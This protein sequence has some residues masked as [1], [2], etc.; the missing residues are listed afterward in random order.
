[1][2]KGLGDIDLVA[3]VGGT[4]VPIE[5]KSFRIWSQFLFFNGKREA[6]TIAQAGR[7]KSRLKADIAFVWL[8][9]GRPTMLQR[10]FGAGGSRDIKVIFGSEKVLADALAR[11]A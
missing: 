6:R 8:P 4:P 5:I 1:M 11:S 2:V 7:Q 10:F 9:Q 3:Y